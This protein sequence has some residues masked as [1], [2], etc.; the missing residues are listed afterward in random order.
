MPTN[1]LPTISLKEMTMDKKIKLGHGNWV[2]GDQFWDREREIEG[3]T[4]LL[5]EGAHILLVA[6]RR[7]GKTSL[8]REVARRIDGRYIC[9]QVD[10]Q[11]SHSPADALVELSVATRPH[12]KIWDRTLDIFRN[13]MCMVKDTVESLKIDDLTLTFRSGLTS[14]DLSAKG[15]RFWAP[16]PIPKSP[17]LYFLMKS[18]SWSIEC[19]KGAIIGS[20]RSG[21]GRWMVLCPG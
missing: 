15:D 2:V 14:G 1:V 17:L 5:D 19:S 7:I 20:P 21:S 10:L 3:F 18:P 16:L 4:E 13:A 11:K 6:P 8:M 9:L 12:K